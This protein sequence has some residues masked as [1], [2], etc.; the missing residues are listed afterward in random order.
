M[1]LLDMKEHTATKLMSIAGVNNYMQA[2]LQ[3][4]MDFEGLAEYLLL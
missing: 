1:V 2:V 3:P 4:I